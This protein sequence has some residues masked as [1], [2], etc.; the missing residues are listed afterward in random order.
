MGCSPAG[1]LPF[2]PLLRKII[3][4]IFIVQINSAMTVL[5]NYKNSRARSF[6][7]AVIC[8]LIL[9]GCASSA[10]FKTPN[11]VNKRNRTIYFEDGTVKK[12]MITILLENDIPEANVIKFIPD[13]ETDSRNINIKEIKSY[14]IDG[15][16]Y[17]PKLIYLDF[18]D[19]HLLFVKRLT[20]ENDRMQ[21][22]E[23][24]QLY[25][26]NSEGQETSYYFI[27][28]PF[29][30]K[31]EVV[32]INGTK[33]IPLFD[34]KMGDYVS[35]CPDL[36]NKIRTKQKRYFYTFTSLRPK[37]LEVIERIVKEYNSCQ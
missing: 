34:I 18:R 7:W 3:Y 17:V 5:M 32:D 19:Y 4:S 2:V 37:K 20:G 13:G 10:Y 30:S 25:K 28:H 11:D 24:H 23:L 14:F 33:L 35:D 31:Y 36:F 15:N 1:Y 8:S 6:L 29:F 26:S 22:Y 16:V 12:G 21:L 27:S 9:S